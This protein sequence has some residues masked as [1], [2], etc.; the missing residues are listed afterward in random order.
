LIDYVILC[1]NA[2]HEAEARR[3]VKKPKSEIITFKAE[4]KMLALLE[5]IPNR[6][7][8]IRSAVL[9]ALGSVCPLCAG[10]G[11]LTP[12]QKEHWDDFAADHE[13][14]ECDECHEVYVVCGNKRA[15]RSRKRKRRVGGEKR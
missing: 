7:E 4:E 15:G 13:L 1:I 2:L 6:S 5:G 8:F 10:T 3:Q 14:E 9:S 12:N 11:I